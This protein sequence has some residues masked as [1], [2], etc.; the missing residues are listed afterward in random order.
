MGVEKRLC[1]SFRYSKNISKDLFSVRLDANAL[2]INKINE[3]DQCSP[4]V[5]L[6]QCRSDDKQINRD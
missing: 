2:E 4:G 5:R 1:Y 6:I 3:Q